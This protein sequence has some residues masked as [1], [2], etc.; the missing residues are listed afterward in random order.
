MLDRKDRDLLK[1]L[2]LGVLYGGPSAEREVSLDSGENVA[3]ALSAAGH[4]VQRVVL[5]GSF[6]SKDAQALGIDIAF[7]A[8]H[9]EFGEDGRIQEILETAAIPYT[10][11]GVDSSSMAYD[12]V[13]A[14]RAFE[15]A[16]VRTPAWMCFDITETDR[17]GAATGLYLAPPVVVKP[18]TGGSSLGVSIVRAEQQ[19]QPALTKASEYSDCVLVERYIPGRELTVGILGETPLPPAELQLAGEFYDYNAKYNDD[20][21]RIVCPAKLEPAAAESVRALAL[22]A[23]RALGCRDVS[24]TDMILDAVGTPWVLEVNTLPGMTSHSLLPRAAAAAGFSFVELCEA[25]L[26][27][28]LRRALAATGRQAV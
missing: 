15:R 2:A 12:K 22:A 14:K 20:R 11:S 1:G 19:V 21:T 10:G 13:L 3:K 17:Q 4:D 9:G 8:L 6:S 18:A 7:L 28:A 24:R 5:D 16:N 26:C 23:H 25:L 27:M